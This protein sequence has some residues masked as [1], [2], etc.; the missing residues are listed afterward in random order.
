MLQKSSV[1]EFTFQKTI[2]IPTEFQ[3]TIQQYQHSLE[4]VKPVKNAKK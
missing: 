2:D 4:E 3:A 1:N